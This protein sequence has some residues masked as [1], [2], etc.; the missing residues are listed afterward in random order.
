MRP[1]NVIVGAVC[2]IALGAG[3]I[4]AVEAGTETA[5]AQGGFTVSAA[6]LRINQSI[7]SA[8]V[9][10]GNRALN[11]LAPI[12]TT[13]SDNADTGRN[14]VRP[15]TQVPGSGQGWTSGQI[16]D[17]AVTRAKIAGE[18]VDSEK[19]APGGVTSGDLANDSVTNEKIGAAAVGSGEIG[20]GAVTS[21]KVADG[22]IG[23]AKLDADAARGL[24]Y[25]GWVTG[26]GELKGTRGL[27]GVTKPPATSG[28]YQVATAFPVATESCAVQVTVDDPTGIGFYGK[29]TIAGANR[30]D[31]RIYRGDSDGLTN[32]SFSITVHCV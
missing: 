19:I 5:G 2:G 6:Q 22:A 18:A 16:G 14:G 17:S 9:R 26:G 30:I 11:Y 32:E 15:L 20:S 10:R 3:A 21:G 28:I 27:T 24:A 13:A 7:S 4:A 23:T 8:A 12:R 1:K 29:Y 31:V 25:F